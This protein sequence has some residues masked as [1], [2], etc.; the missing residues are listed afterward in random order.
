MT[1]L[2]LI[3]KLAIFKDQILIAVIDSIKEIVDPLGYSINVLDPEF[4]TRSIDYDS[5]RL[6]VWT[7]AKSVI[8]S[9]TIG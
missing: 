5:K 2:R 4:N 9:F 1:R 7:D 3:K 8:R 6:N